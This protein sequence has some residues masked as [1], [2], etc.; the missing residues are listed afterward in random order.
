MT[1]G[2]VGLG[3]MG[4]RR[5]RLLQKIDAGFSLVGIDAR[6]DRREEAQK[7]YGITVSEDLE[8]AIEEHGIQAVVVSTSPC[9]MGGSSKQ[10]CRRTA[11]CLQN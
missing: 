10:H 7:L 9:L 3:S 2:I 1:I 6:E 4:K 8:K 11:M 5:I